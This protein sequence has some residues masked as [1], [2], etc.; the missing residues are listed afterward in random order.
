MVNLKSTQ[1]ESD[2]IKISNLIRLSRKKRNKRLKKTHKS[3]LSGGGRGS[4]VKSQPKKKTEHKKKVS[5]EQSK[6]S[7]T[8]ILEIVCEVITYGGIKY[9]LD[10]NDNI[11]SY[12]NENEQYYLVG[13]K[14]SDY[15]KFDKD[16]EKM[17]H[18]E[19]NK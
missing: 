9:L 18:S 14:V 5:D 19:S 11:Y 6:E 4:I 17:I 2:N 1:S 7:E 16:Y 12:P 3:F 10:K 15:I 13:K 8:H